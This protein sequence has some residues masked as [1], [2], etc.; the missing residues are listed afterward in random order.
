MMRKIAS[1]LFAILILSLTAVPAFAAGNTANSQPDIQVEIVSPT[2][3]ETTPIYD[4]TIEIAVT[5]NGDTAVQNLSCYLTIV[6]VGRSQTYPVDEFGEEAYQTRSISSLA[7]GESATISIPVHIMYV[8]DFRFTAS[9][10]CAAT[11]QIFSGTALNVLMT[12]TSS[13]NK[14]LVMIVAIIVPILLAIAA[15]LLVRRKNRNQ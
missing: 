1:C 12:S 3:I 11:G 14:S 6:D 13:L 2:S 7:P 5:N 15:F 9:V 10:L 4:D 8:G